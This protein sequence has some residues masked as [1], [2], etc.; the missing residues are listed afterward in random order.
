[1]MDV[2]ENLDHKPMYL[3]RYVYGIQSGQYIKIGVAADIERRMGTMRLYNP[4]PFALVFKRKTACAYHCERRMHE[5]LGAKAIG[6]EWFEVTLDEVKAAAVIGLSEARAAF[7][8]Q[9][10]RD[11]AWR[12]QLRAPAT[13]APAVQFVATKSETSTNTM[14]S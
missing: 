9:L 11:I 3:P 2:I 10:K 14:L 5:I 1:M 6:R 8:E 7:R 12:L 4:H 13:N